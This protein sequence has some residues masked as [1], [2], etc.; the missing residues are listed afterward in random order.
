MT[1]RIRHDNELPLFLYLLKHDVF[2]WIMDNDI[3]IVLLSTELLLY[4]GATVVSTGICST[5]LHILYV[6]RTAIDLLVRSSTVLS[7]RHRITGIVRHDSRHGPV[8][9]EYSCTRVVVQLY[10]NLVSISD[11]VACAYDIV[12]SKM[13]SD[14]RFSSADGEA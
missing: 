11:T 8:A 2:E 9:L 5:C 12:H 4:H 1:K 13:L 6:H 7:N 3:D 10:S 14:E